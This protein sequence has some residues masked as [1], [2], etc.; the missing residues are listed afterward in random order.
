M[1]VLTTLSEGVQQFRSLLPGPCTAVQKY[2]QPL[3]VCLAMHGDGYHTNRWA[4]FQTGFRQAQSITFTLR[5]VLPGA[6]NCQYI[7]A[8]GCGSDPE[9][10]FVVKSGAALWSIQNVMLRVELSWLF[11]ERFKFY[12]EDSSCLIEVVHLPLKLLSKSDKF[13]LEDFDY[14][15]WKEPNSDLDAHV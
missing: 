7:V 9:G 2:L 15:Q 3:Q 1:S 6:C 4:S 12:L 11:K 5:V 13:L 10:H 8:V 14:S